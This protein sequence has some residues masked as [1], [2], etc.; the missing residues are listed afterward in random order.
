MKL[1]EINIHYTCL[2]K[3]EFK[4]LFGVIWKWL[5]LKSGGGSRTRTNACRICN[6]RHYQ[7]CY[8][9]KKIMIFLCIY[10]YKKEWQRTRDSNPRRLSPRRFSKPVQSTNSVN[11]LQLNGA[12][13]ENR[14]HTPKPERDFKSRASTY[15]AT[16]AFLLRTLLSFYLNWTGII[17]AFFI[18]VKSFLIFFWNYKITLFL[19]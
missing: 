16:L 10:F 8:S 5:R 1:I 3:H 14:T 12:N 18:F 4:G 19:M 13:G 15:S 2:T 6:P 11:P 7:L 17:V 9:S